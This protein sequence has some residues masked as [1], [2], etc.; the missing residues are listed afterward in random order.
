M[1]A[2]TERFEMRLDTGTGERVDAWRARQSDVPSRSEAVRRL[3]DVGLNAKEHAQI[4]DGEK[5]ILFMLCDMYSKTVKNG[6]MEPEFIKSAIFGGHYWG[7][8]WKLTGLLHDHRASNRALGEVVDI[9]DM[10]SFIEEAYEKFDQSQRE[11]I[12]KEAEPFGEYVEFRGFDGNN[13]AEHLSITRFMIEDMGRFTRFSKR[14]LNSH[15]PILGR[16]LRMFNVF[17]PMRKDL[18]GHGL[19]P[20]QVITILRA[21]IAY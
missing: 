6:E 16:H 15:H 9:L 18:V 10:W 21:G 17:E 4:S 14:D 19:S 5:L 8:N 11:R 1:Q 20:E 13:E 3:I 2:K 7:L 12:K